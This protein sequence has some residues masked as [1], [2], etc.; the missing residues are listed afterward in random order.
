MG[1]DL[2]IN[3]VESQEAAGVV[4]GGEICSAKAL[5]KR[6]AGTD[7]SQRSD[8]RQILRPISIDS[9]L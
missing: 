4:I 5:C 2:R 1:R 7:F 3:A 6:E 8:R 9:L